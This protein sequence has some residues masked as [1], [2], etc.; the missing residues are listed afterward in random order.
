MSVVPMMHTVWSGTRMSPSS[1][2]T[3]RLRTVPVSR[4]FIAIMMPAPGTTSTPWQ[5]PMAAIW[6]AHGPPQLTTKPHS[7]RRSSPP[8]S[9]WTTTAL[10]R[11]PSRSM[12]TTLW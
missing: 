4:W 11:S 5:S 3:Q 10:T 2:H 9:S 7:T 8:L 12:E 1:G 6:P